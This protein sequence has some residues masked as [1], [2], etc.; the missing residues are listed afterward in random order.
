MKYP[1]SNNP[2]VA[3]SSSLKRNPTTS[4]IIF[5]PTDDNNKGRLDPN[6]IQMRYYE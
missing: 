1:Y 5:G 2:L 6:L 4:E 3:G